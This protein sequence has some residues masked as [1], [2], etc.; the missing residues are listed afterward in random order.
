[1][2]TVYP[3]IGI[4]ARLNLKVTQQLNKETEELNM[5][6]LVNLTFDLPQF[7]HLEL[8]DN[9]HYGTNLDDVRQRWLVDRIERHGVNHM[10][11]E[12]RRLYLILED[13]K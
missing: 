3:T 10:E 7:A 11:A 4:L 2:T 1:M 12:A 8:W 13:L 6:E 5:V 9:F